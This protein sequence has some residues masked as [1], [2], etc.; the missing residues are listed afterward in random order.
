[1]SRH[2]YVLIVGQGRSGTNWLLQLLDRSARTFCRNEPYGAVESPLNALNRHR[3][4]VRSDQR[5]LEAQWDEAARWTSC[6]MGDRDPRVPVRKHHIYEP[7]RLLGPYRWVHGPR[8]RG[9]LSRFSPSLRGQEWPVPWWLGNAGRLAS[10][11][12]V[13]KL[14]APPGWASFVLK[15]RPGIPVIHI[16]RHPGGF[17]NSWSK[18]YLATQEREA[19]RR[20]N[21]ERL[22]DIVGE[23]PAWG[24][25]FGDIEAMDAEESELCYWRYANEVVYLAGRESVD[26]HNIAY[27]DLVADP[28]GVMKPLYEACGLVLDESIE[29]SVRKTEMA[30]NVA[31]A[32]RENLSEARLR[33]VERFLQE[34]RSFYHPKRAG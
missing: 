18:R 10:S 32:W 23:D 16:I 22:R 5:E 14:V 28:V 31:G 29:R 25:V 15:Q 26:Y 34:G 8:L 3:F 13:L 33:L 19:V 7:S 4:V 24:A 1:V 20:A 12:P 27:E 30:S 21:Q 11:L 9:V 6:H 17:L 2:D